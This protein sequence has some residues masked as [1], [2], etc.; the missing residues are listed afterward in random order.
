MILVVNT[1]LIVNEDE[2]KEKLK[3]IFEEIAPAII[4]RIREKTATR[5]LMTIAQAAD[6]LQ[7]STQSIVNWSRRPADQNPL[8]AC[9]AGAD[10]RFYKTELDAWLARGSTMKSAPK[11]LLESK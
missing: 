3:E 6:Y 8:P 7:C 11:K 10:P 1:A 2:L 4:E 5:E 9:Y